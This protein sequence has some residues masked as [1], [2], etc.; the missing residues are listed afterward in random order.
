MTI[1]EKI[2]IARQEKG[3]TQLELSKKI[4][5]SRSAIACYETERRIPD[6]KDLQKI[7]SMLGVSVEYF[8]DMHPNNELN[9]FV[10]RATALF[11]NTEIPVNEKDNI[12]N[13][14]MKIYIKYK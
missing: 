5:C 8:A 10:L 9:D 3:F 14:I 7:A 4:G 6:F 11:S 1:G 2:K 12:F 13:E